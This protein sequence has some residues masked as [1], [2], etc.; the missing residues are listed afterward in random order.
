MWTWGWSLCGRPWG[1]GTS[2]RTTIV[3]VAEN[4]VVIVNKVGLHAR[5]ARL[6][7]QTAA[8]F[9]ARIQVQCSDKTANA[10]RIVGVLKLGAALGDTLKLHAEGEDAEEAL[11]ALTELVERKF[12]E[13]E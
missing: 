13:D 10:K 9:Q 8:Q 4:S 3:T 1:L 7:V 12:D 11:R 5:P 2:G 6:L